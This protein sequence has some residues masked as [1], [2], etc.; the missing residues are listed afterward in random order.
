VEACVE[1]ARWSL[2]AGDLRRARTLL[3][4]GL[5]LA[6]DHPDLLH[7]K[8]NVLELEGFRRAAEGCYGDVLGDHP[9]RTATRLARGRV[10]LELGL[11]HAARGD[12]ERCIAEGEDGGGTWLA[13]AQ[14]L[15][16]TGAGRAAFDA[17]ARAFERGAADAHCLAAAAHLLVDGDVRP[18]TKRDEQL[19][20]SWLR[21]AITLSPDDDGPALELARLHEQTG[22]LDAARDCLEQLLE[23]D[24]QHLGALTRLVAIHEERGDARGAADAARRAL[25]FERDPAQ[26][27]RLAALCGASSSVALD[28]KR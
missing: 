27:A 2:A 4:E 28:V 19:A 17:F 24:P 11:A 15:T 8:G 10:R 6:P 12:L 21:R 22:D 18:R 26:R 3:G 14:A 20:A 1:A 23:R 7:A 9:D 16:A 13:Y 5:E 25:Q